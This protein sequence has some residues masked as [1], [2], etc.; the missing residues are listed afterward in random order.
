MTRN[1]PITPS[2]GWKPSPDIASRKVAEEMVLLNVKTSEY[3]SL[4]PTAALVWEAISA[5]RKFG[6]I[7]EAVAERFE[8]G[9]AA[10]E[11]DVAGLIRGLEADKIV[12]RTA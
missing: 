4:N 8:V 3:Y 9:Q 12:S 2:S 11:K 5:G 1:G 6:E 7:V 10:V